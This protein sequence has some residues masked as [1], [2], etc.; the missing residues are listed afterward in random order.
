MPEML[1]DPETGAELWRGEADCT[2]QCIYGRD[3]LMPGDA[4]LNVMSDVAYPDPKCALHGGIADVWP[5]P[6]IDLT[7]SETQRVA[8]ASAYE[9]GA[10]TEGH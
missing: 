2:G 1:Y 8:L 10:L 3:I 7:A 6:E 9:H 4:P 5:D